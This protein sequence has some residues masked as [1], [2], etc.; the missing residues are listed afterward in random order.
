MIQTT[1]VSFCSHFLFLGFLFFFF[2]IF[3]VYNRCWEVIYRILVSVI[4]HKSTG[5]FSVS[6]MA[7]TEPIIRTFRAC[8]CKSRSITISTRKIP[9]LS[10]FLVY[11]KVIV[12]LYSLLILLCLMSLAG[13]SLF[14]LFWACL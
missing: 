4:T 8:V 2:F 6:V 7:P 14:H 1:N 11:Y 3:C 5:H 13:F 10:I 9:S 12:Y